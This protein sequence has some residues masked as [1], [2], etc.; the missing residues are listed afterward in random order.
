MIDKKRELEKIENELKR[1][2]EG[3]RNPTQI[4]IEKFVS[5]LDVVRTVPISRP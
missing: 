1:M 4:K 5:P 2:L 3:I